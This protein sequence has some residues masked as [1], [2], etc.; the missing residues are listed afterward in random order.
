MFGPNGP[1]EAP[2]QFMSIE[3]GDSDEI[4]LEILIADANH[5]LGQAKEGAVVSQ[6]DCANDCTAYFGSVEQSE[7]T[8]KV[9]SYF[10]IIRGSKL[11][12]AISAGFD[13][14][15]SYDDAKNLIED[16]ARQIMAGRI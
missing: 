15:Y 6:V 16:I 7:S 4:S 11:S 1:Y 9:N 13:D 8:M 2:L 5:I 12:A 3:Y 14:S 10:Y